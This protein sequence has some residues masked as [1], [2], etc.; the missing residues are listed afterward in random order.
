[1]YELLWD[2]AGNDNDA[3]NTLKISGSF[4]F[5]GNPNFIKLIINMILRLFHLGLCC[6]TSLFVSSH[7]HCALASLLVASMMSLGVTC[8]SIWKSAAVASLDKRCPFTPLKMENP[9]ESMLSSW[10]RLW[11]QSLLM[12]WQV[13]S[14]NKA[15]WVELWN[16]EQ[17]W[18]G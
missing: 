18:V 2:R 3:P 6:R 13:T 10:H 1:M 9:A 12:A 4:S 8:A 16:R 14:E 15:L 7:G 17:R 11:H 5:S